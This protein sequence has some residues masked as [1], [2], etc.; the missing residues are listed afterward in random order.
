MKAAER[1]SQ[2]RHK[3]YLKELEIAEAEDAVDSWKDYIHDLIS[4]HADAA[5][6]MDWAAIANSPRPSEPSQS[7]FHHS[8]A[9]AELDA[10]KPRFFDFLSG[11]SERKRDVLVQAVDIGAQEDEREYAEAHNRYQQALVDWESD[12]L[13][14][15]RLLDGEVAAK[16]D[17]IGEFQSL[18]SESRI[19]SEVSFRINEEWLHAVATVHTDEVVPNYRRKQ[20][21]SGRL[22]ETKM[23]VGEFNELYQ[24][25]VCSVA[26]KVAGDLFGLLPD[27]EVFVTCRALMLNSATGHQ[28]QTPVLSV[29]FVRETYRRLNLA[30]ID[31]SDSL[32][33]FN[34]HMAF[35][36]TKGFAQ[37]E[38]LRPVDD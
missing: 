31:P 15:K 19:G 20:L 30:A 32:A 2:R 29:Q 24:D 38:P 9:I 33:N 1:E 18:T 6:D 17:V 11:G 21:A 3:Q 16:R 4:I 23:P 34:H 7:D 35:K 26:L 28:E 5:D 22:S 27:N 13:L 8:K 10:F 14:A 12:A 25:Y 37:I 36:R